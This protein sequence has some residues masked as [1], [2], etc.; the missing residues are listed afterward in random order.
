[1]SPRPSRGDALLGSGVCLMACLLLT[2]ELRYPKPSI[3]LRPS[4]GVTLGGAVTVWC[5]GRHQN[6][7]FLLHKF[8]NPNVLQDVVLAGNVAEFP[9]RNVSRRDA[10]SYRCYYRSKSDPPVW[11]EPSD[12]VELAIAGEGPPQ[13]PHSQP[14]P[15]PREPT[16][17]GSRSRIHPQ[18]SRQEKV[19]E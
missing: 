15:Q 17:M 5:R 14:H 11:S 6:M 3:S 16:Q 4:A 9:I 18:R 12:P 2:A 13:R 7:R 10:G 8:G 19:S 1:M